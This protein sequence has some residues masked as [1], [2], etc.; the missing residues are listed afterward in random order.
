MRA[1]KNT[2]GYALRVY[3]DTELRDML[4]KEAKSFGL[5]SLSAMAKFILY[6]YLKKKAK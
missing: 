2:T 1:K 4:A 6:D 5:S 3:M